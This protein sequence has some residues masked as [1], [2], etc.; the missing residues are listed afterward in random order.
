MKLS[1]T[2]ITL[3]EALNLD[4]CLGGLKKFV[5]EIVVVDSGSSDETVAIAKKFGAK[6]LVRK[7]SNFAE[8]KN[9]AMENTSGEWVLSVDADEEITDDLGSEIKVAI[10]NDKYDGYLI[11]RRNFI[12]GGEIKYSRWSPDRHI[13]LWKKDKGGWQ[14]MVHEE[15][16]VK[17][18]VGL[19]KNSKIHN[20][21]KTIEEFIAKN[22]RYSTLEAEK[23]FEQGQ[24]FSWWKMIY[25]AAFEW[26]IRYIY[27]MGF[28]DG[29]RGLVLAKLMADFKREVWLKLL[30]REH[31]GDK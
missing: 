11:G 4:R 19:L 3:N 8:Q 16:V 5:D 20:Q 12:L 2:V 27:K 14:G 7:F 18:D 21:D 13:W 1:A 17:G 15:V 23:M 22:N 30:E 25:E 29:W 24:R 31:R 6:V 10:E 26:F 9:Y 28:R